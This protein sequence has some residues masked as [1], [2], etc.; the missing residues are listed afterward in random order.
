MIPLYKPFVPELPEIEN[1][2]HSGA[3]A[4]GAYTK[5]FE[6]R[7]KSYF[8]QNEIAAVNSFHSAISVVTTTLGLNHGDE[9]IAS[10]MA[11]LAS[12]QPYAVEGLNIIWADID[13]FLG[14]LSPDSVRS[15]ITSK[16]K[17]IIHN[18]FCGYPGY[19]DEINDIGKEYGI[20]VIDDGIECFGTTYRDKKI[21]ACGTDASVF[22][23]NPVRMLTTID[24]GAIMFNDKEL[25]EQS[26]LIR[27]CGI[28]RSLFRDDMGE[29]NPECDISIHG[30][31]ATLSNVNAYIGSQQ[32]K[33]L[34]TRILAHRKNANL[35][36]EKIKE[37]GPYSPLKCEHGEPNY[38]VYG[39]LASNKVECIKRFREMGYYASGVHIRNDIYKV[40]GGKKNL[41][42]VEAFTNS[43][44][45]I[46]CGW[47]MEVG[48][49]TTNSHR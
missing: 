41:P 29:I 3:L 12:T 26:L 40:F 34:E 28:N 48:N 24:G 27:D 45:A 35:W 5:E 36:D 33:N 46:P 44:V 16:T 21:G 14:T 9:V 39:I 6:N 32:M 7:L 17:A 8:N 23:F 10:P 1:I 18:H 2:L 30:Y 13:P 19:I 49:E 4:A 15:E 20:A 22:S 42:G 11:C 47:W 38:W 25:F 43:F 31:S 37:I